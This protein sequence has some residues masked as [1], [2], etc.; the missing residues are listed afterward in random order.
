ML[1]WMVRWAGV[2]PIEAAH[3]VREAAIPTGYD[4]DEHLTAAQGGS[5]SFRPLSRS[6]RD[7]P[8]MTEARGREL[9]YKLYDMNP[10]AKRIPELIRDFVLGE[11]VT[12]EAQG[13]QATNDEQGKPIEDPARTRLQAVIDAFW[14]DPVNR[15][16]LTL[17]DKILEF[18]IAGEQCYPVMI[19]PKNGHARLG[20]IDPGDIK[21]VIRH[22]VT[23][24][25]F[26]VCLKDAAGTN[27]IRYKVIQVQAD[28][29]KPWFGRMLDVERDAQGNVTETYTA[30]DDEKAYEG[31][32]FFWA[33]NKP[34]SATRGRSDLL[35][36]VDWLD[37]FDQL[38]F[39]EVDRALLMKAFIWDVTVQNADATV[40]AK[41]KS[42]LSVP[43]PGSLNL[44][45]GQETWE[46]IAPSL[47][48]ADNDILADRILSI[49]ATGAGLPKTY[50]NGA[51]DVNR[52]S[53]QELDEA[54]LKR[55]QNR[56]KLV[57]AI[58][59]QLVTFALDQAEIKGRLP[60]RHQATGEM[61]AA[62]PVSVN[63]PEMVSRDLAGLSAALKTTADALTVAR[64]DL[65]I[66]EQVHQEA[67]AGVLR[68][69]G[70]EVDLPSMRKR[71]VAEKA[72]KEAE[73]DAMRQ[74][75]LDTGNDDQDDDDQDQPSLRVVGRG[76]GA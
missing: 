36:L 63:T 30:G 5:A 54:P 45:N 10:L 4:P 1:D 3:P 33:I 31:A 25:P 28:P 37:A 74:T 12:V 65:V 39:G 24:Q 14:L 66:D 34:I 29:A 64:A 43:K 44:H 61:P 21:E 16:D 8:A 60:K 52:A 71:L 59:H 19:N 22:P 32:C 20:Y 70:A 40:L 49:V 62:W 58:I 42:E 73:R 9:A 57:K 17:D 41:R 46:A 11:G 38:M 76:A 7:L 2:P 55:L 69:L 47:N 15:L 75:M 68:H 13:E 56:Q 27:D 18:S 51:M 26:A 67:F 48:A 23:L 53:A 50:L 35:C 6:N 72:E